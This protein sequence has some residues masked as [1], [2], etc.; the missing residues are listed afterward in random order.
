MHVIIKGEQK[1][2]KFNFFSIEIYFI[3]LLKKI[4]FNSLW[5]LEKCAKYID[6]VL[7]NLHDSIKEDE[8]NIQNNKH[9][10][11]AQ[12]LTLKEM[13]MKK[14]KFLIQSTLQ[15]CAILSQLDQ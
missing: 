9:L 7:Y 2:K 3:I 10:G 8:I 12:I 15:F 1:E 11:K 4:R 14:T 13:K 5:L 6:G